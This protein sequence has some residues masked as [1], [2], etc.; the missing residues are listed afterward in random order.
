M[1][2]LETGKVAVYPERWG[3]AQLSP[4]EGLPRRNDDAGLPNLLI[5]PPNKSRN[6]DFFL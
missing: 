5:P 1:D 3:Q 4:G 6:L 2:V